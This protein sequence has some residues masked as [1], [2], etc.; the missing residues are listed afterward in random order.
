[1]P[2]VGNT[3]I[4][5]GS[6][7]ISYSAATPAGS[8]SSPA[9]APSSAIE[10]SGASGLT[11][12]PQIYETRLATVSL[13]SH[14][15]LNLSTRPIT[16]VPAPGAGM[17]LILVLAIY[18]TTFGTSAYTGNAQCYYGSTNE[19]VDMGDGNAFQATSNTVATAASFCEYN[20]SQVFTPMTDLINQPIVVGA[21][22][23]L[24]GGDGTGTVSVL[25]YTL[26]I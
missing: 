25:Y 26:P 20:G 22:V 15:L 11:P 2:L 1:M 21:S 24:A 4:T 6:G 17:V 9:P 3:R 5:P 7:R 14:D 10:L 18:R 12:G 23:T 16:L 8:P 13:S 19:M